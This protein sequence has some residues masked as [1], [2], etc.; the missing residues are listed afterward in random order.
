MPVID[1]TKPRLSGEN[2]IIASLATVGL[3]IGVYQTTVGPISDVHAT[4]PHDINLTKSMRKAGW[5]AFATVAAIGLLAKDMN[6]IILGG[7]TIIVEE[8]G[9]RHALMSNPATGQ[10]QSTPS[11]Y[12]PAGAPGSGTLAAMPG[13]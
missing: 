7:A 6:I 12:L 1:L 5:L 2:S 13:H 3:V 9:Y 4:E 11:A 10:I 8:L